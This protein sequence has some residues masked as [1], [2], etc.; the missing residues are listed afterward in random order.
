M[1]GW[2]A[3]SGRLPGREDGDAQGC[4]LVW[5]AF[6][7]VMVTGWHNIAWN[8]FFTHWMQ[9]PRGPG[10]EERDEGTKGSERSM[11][12]YEEREGFL[13]IAGRIDRLLE[14]V[15]YLPGHAAEELASLLRQ[16]REE[17]L[18]Q[19][20]ERK[21]AACEEVRADYWELEADYLRSR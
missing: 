11:S 4:V 17:A 9:T 19:A 14:E 1:K 20:E 7:G 18:T 5:H 16:A 21:E 6:N 2:V 8:R 10:S 13:D 15:D 12:R 3:V